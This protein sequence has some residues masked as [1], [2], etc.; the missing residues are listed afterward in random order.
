[1]WSRVV[2]IML[3]CWLLM[4]PFLFTHPTDATA[5]WVNDLVCGTAVILFGVF[6]YWGPTRQAHLLSLAVGT[7]LI[8]F[9]YREGFGEPSAAS[10][11]HVILGLL[12]LMFA[13]I[14]NDAAEAAQGWN[15]EPAPNPRR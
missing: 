6:S 10:Q 9:A 15:A 5:L 14:P 2:E 8:A 1:M 13:I 11:N 12:L 3:G 7:W 4:S